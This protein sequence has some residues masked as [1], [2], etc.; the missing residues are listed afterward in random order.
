MRVN[1]WLKEANQWPKEPIMYLSVIK[2]EIYGSVSSRRGADIWAKLWLKRAT[3]WS[4]CGR[5]KPTQVVKNGQRDT[6]HNSSY[7][8]Q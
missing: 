1:Q 3:K 7:V 2:G 4:N 5:V 6:M 8:T